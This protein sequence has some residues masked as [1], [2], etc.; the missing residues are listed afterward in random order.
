MDAL[1]AGFFDG[2]EYSGAQ[3]GAV[4]LLAACAC[5]FGHC[6]VECGGAELGGAVLTAMIGCAVGAELGGNTGVAG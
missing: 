2:T 5:A 3:L 4:H 1:S 6:D